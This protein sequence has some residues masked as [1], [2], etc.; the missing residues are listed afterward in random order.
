MTGGVDL[1]WDQINASDLQRRMRF[2]ADF[3]GDG[4]LTSEEAGMGA[5]ANA[6]MMDT[7]DKRDWGFARQVRTGI[8]FKF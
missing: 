1:R 8:D 2:N 3:N 7:M 5:L 6:V 4:I